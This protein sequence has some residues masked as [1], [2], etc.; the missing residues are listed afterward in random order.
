MEVTR[1]VVELQYGVFN[2]KTLEQFKRAIN[3]LKVTNITFY[4]NDIIKCQVKNLNGSPTFFTRYPS[5]DNDVKT[6]L[7]LYNRRFVR[8]E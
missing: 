8:N 5:S 6:L 4:N 7:Q 1:I 3:K 2:F